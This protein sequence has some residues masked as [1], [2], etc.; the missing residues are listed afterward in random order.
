[1]HNVKSILKD[2]KLTIEIDVS[3][4]QIDDA[5]LSSSG[6]NKLVASTGGHIPLPDSDMK[7]NLTLTH[8]K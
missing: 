7:L 1:M 2:G 6:K 4:K 8:P 5:A 3:K